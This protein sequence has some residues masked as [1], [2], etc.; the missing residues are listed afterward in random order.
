MISS[1][2]KSNNEIKK[3]KSPVQWIKN[4][5]CCVKLF[6][7]MG[8]QFFSLNKID[9][10]YIDKKVSLKW[11][12]YLIFIMSSLSILAGILVFVDDYEKRNENVDVTINNVL[13]IAVRKVMEASFIIVIV[14]SILQSFINV[15]KWKKFYLNISKIRKINQSELDCDEDFTNFKK[16][17]TRKMAIFLTYFAFCHVLSCVFQVSHN[18][19][20]F[21]LI[22]FLAFL[23]INFL[24]VVALRMIFY[25]S[26]INYLLKNLQKSLSRTYEIQAKISF[27]KNDEKQII[28]DRS[29]SL[30]SLRKVFNL[31]LESANILDNVW[32]LSL[33]IYLAGYIIAITVSEYQFLILMVDEKLNFSELFSKL[34]LIHFLCDQD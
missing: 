8:L 19:K 18:V 27:I 30:L 6:Q 22:T 26:L 15:K 5:D 28:S 12:I 7:L 34:N 13:M 11:K 32:G 14:S 29:K 17:S 25:V 2:N 23:P 1:N 20:H 4:L 10:Q 33:I 16:A 24:T 3:F 21:Y 31:I 9:S